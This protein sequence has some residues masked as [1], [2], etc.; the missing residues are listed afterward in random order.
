MKIQNEK[1][2]TLASRFKSCLI[3]PGPD[4]IICDEGHFLK[5]DKTNLAKSVNLVETKRRIVL[6]GTPLQNNLIE[7]HC[8]VSFVKPNLLGTKKEFMNRFVN[9]IYNGQHKGNKK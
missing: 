7:Y 6:T 5:S 4:L 3:S 1:S 9:P 2:S 8:M